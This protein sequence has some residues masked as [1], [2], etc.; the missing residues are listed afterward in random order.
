MTSLGW[1]VLTDLLAQSVDRKKRTPRL[2]SRLMVAA[3]A[4]L[5]AAAISFMLKKTP[6]VHSVHFY[7]LSFRQ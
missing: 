5:F 3:F 4:L 7:A 2:K 6:Q 1:L